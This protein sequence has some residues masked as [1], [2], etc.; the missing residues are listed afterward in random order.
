MWGIQMTSNYECQ[1]GLL[2]KKLGNAL[3]RATS[4]SAVTPSG[5]CR[6][7]FWKSFTDQQF[8]FVAHWDLTIHHRLHHGSCPSFVDGVGMW[9]ARIVICPYK[10]NKLSHKSCPRFL[11]RR[12][13]TSKISQRQQSGILAA[14]E[15]WDLKFELSKDTG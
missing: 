1:T 5:A 10:T 12:N 2:V 9:M 3:P 11:W 6:T 8:C 7:C 4:G 15:V 13:K 14:G